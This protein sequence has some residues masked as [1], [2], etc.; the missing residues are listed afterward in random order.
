RCGFDGCQPYARALLQGQA[1][2]N[3]CPPGGE[4][5]RLALA[6]LLH[7]EPLP[8]TEPLSPEPRV[9]VA[10]D[11]KACIGCGR[12][13]P[14]CPVDAIAGA[15]GYLH[16]VVTQEC[17]GCQ[18]CLA[19]CPV[20]CFVVI[21][22][23][24]YEKGPWTDRSQS[25]ARRARLRSDLKRRRTRKL[26]RPES[27]RTNR[28]HKRQEIKEALARIRQQRGWQAGA[29]ARRIAPTE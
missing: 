25:E 1:A 22:D 12:C 28:D 29:R 24:A 14:A 20:D 9:R 2:I 7:R 10:I 11:P 26:A 8:W 5:T 4:Y 3:R 15:V 6:Q 17:T 16:A 19:P 27:A 18:L 23:Q 21:S 13:L